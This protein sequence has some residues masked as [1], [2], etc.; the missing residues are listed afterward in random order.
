MSQEVTNP[1]FKFR[2]SIPEAHRASIDTRLN[3]LWHQRFGTVQNIWRQ[4]DDLLDKTAATMILQA[5]LGKDL[6]SIQLLFT[7]LEGGYRPDAVIMDE[8]LEDSDSMRL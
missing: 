5:I 2:K 1:Q 3:W 7:R 8:P 6:K 4:T